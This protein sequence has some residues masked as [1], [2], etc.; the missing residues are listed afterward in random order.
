RGIRQNRARS[1]KPPRSGMQDHSSSCGFASLAHRPVA[2]SRLR[3]ALRTL[4]L[5][6]TLVG[7]AATTCH[8]AKRVALVVGNDAYRN[9]SPLRKAVTDASA[10]A[11]ALRGL[12][13]TVLVAENQDRVS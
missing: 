12:G 7:C 8:A 9:I 13:F 2:A 3:L 11:S 6:L 10:I 1:D 5:V 4:A